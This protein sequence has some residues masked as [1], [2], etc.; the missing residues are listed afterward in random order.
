[1]EDGILLPDYRLPTEAEWEYAAY[2]YQSPD[3]N[4]NIDVKRIYPWDGL[5]LRRS[6]PEKERGK[7]YANYIRGRGDAAG[8]A[9]NLNDAFFYHCY[10]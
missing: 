9:G 10:R 5:T 6:E 7:M 3:Y 1:M 4:E 2:G 8:V